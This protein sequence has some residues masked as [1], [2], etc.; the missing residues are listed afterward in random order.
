MIKIFTLAFILLGFSGTAFC[1]IENPVKWNYT[2]KKVADK[3]YDIE[4]TATLDGGWHIYAQDAGEG[5]APTEFTFNRNPLATMVGA[6]TEKG[7]LIK[8][9]DKNFNSVLK[10]YASKVTFVQRIKLRTNAAT[11]FSGT[12]NYMTC[13]DRKCLPPKDVKFSLKVGGK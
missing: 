13:N 7:K 9:F 8:E 5:P 6:T 3:T 2:A 10:F 1:Q 4:I 11:V 12:V